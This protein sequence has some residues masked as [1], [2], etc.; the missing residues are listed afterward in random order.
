MA[1]CTVS[2]RMDTEVRAEF[3]QVCEELGLS[4]SFHSHKYL[5]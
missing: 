2:A 4:I 1:Y 5:C 3:F